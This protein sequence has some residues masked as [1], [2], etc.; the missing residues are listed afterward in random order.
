[1][2]ACVCTHHTPP[3]VLDGLVDVHARPVVQ[4][5]ADAGG[6]VDEPHVVLTFLRDCVETVNQINT[7]AHLS[8]QFPEGRPKVH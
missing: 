8:V 1:M 6:A 2:C 4:H 7:R 3:D 5:V